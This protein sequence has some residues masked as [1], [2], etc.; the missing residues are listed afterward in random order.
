PRSAPAASPPVAL[1]PPFFLAEVRSNFYALSPWLVRLGHV[2]VTAR[3]GASRDLAES[4]WWAAEAGGIHDD[5]ARVRGAED[6]VRSGHGALS[7]THCAL[8][9]GGAGG[10]VLPG[11]P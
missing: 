9:G 10:A 5:P 7:L 11:H 4:S 2:S 6:D 3:C 1:I 8:D